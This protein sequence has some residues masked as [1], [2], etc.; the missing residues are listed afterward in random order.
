MQ[1]PP[2]K[3]AQL[4]SPQDSADLENVLFAHRIPQKGITTALLTAQ[5]PQYCHDSDVP[6]PT[7]QG[8]SVSTIM[9]THLPGTRNAIPD[10]LPTS[11]SKFPAF[12]RPQWRYPLKT[13]RCRV[14]C[15]SQAPVS[16]VFH[17]RLVARERT[18]RVE[19]LRMVRVS[20]FEPRWPIKV[21]LLN[22]LFSRSAPSLDRGTPEASGDAPKSKTVSRS[23]LLGETGRILV[24]VAN[25]PI[26]PNPAGGTG[27]AE[28]R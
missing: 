28:R 19:S 26:G 4:P 23:A 21:T 24:S 3:T 12:V 11:L 27:K 7:G 25:E 14:V 18:V 8:I 20:A 9:T 1:D 15:D 2:T 17:E 10:L 5:S 22:I 16:R 6:T 13:Q